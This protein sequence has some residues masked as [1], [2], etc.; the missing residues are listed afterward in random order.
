MNNDKKLLRTRMIEIRKKIKDK[1]KKSKRIVDKIIHLEVY[2]QAIVICLYKSLVNEVQIDSLIDYS[3]KCGKIVLL[4]KVVDN[5]LIF[6]EYHQND[7]LEKSDFR[8]LEPVLDSK[9]DYQGK[10]DLVIVP[11][12][13]FDKRN[14]R[15]GYGKG[16][17]DCFMKNKDFY[18]IGICYNEQLIDNVPVNYDD[19]ILDLVITD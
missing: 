5:N 7:Q 3:L 18:K 11:G 12:L 2:K 17:Y 16:Y 6:L 15:I 8:V 9:R 19:V 4:P 14:H 10:I 1:N 13:A